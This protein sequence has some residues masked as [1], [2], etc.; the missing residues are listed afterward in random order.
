MKR[1]MVLAALATAAASLQ[2]AAPVLKEPV[3]ALPVMRTS[4][5]V[6]GT[7]DAD[8][9]KDAAELQQ[10][11]PLRQDVVFPGEANVWFG[12][13]DERLYIAARMIVSPHG[14]VKGP[15]P[16]NRRGN[17]GTLGAFGGDCFELDFTSDKDA[18]KESVL[19]MIVS[20]TGCYYSTGTGKGLPV[21]WDPP[22]FKTASTEKDGY[23]LFEY[24]I[25]L[26]EIGFADADWAKHGVRI[27][28]N[29]KWV[30]GN[31]F[32][33]QS[34]LT[35]YE[36]AFGMAAGCVRT[37][38]LDDAPVVQLQT[39]GLAGHGGDRNLQAY[40][41]KLR[42]AN[43]TAKP[44]DL[45]VVL[46]GK[47]VN[48][49]PLHIEMPLTL[50]PGEEKVFDEK[51]AVLSD[52]AVELDVNVTS[53]DGATKY[54]SR[55]MK[56]VPNFYRIEW[57][58]PGVKNATLKCNMAYYPSYNKMRVKSNLSNAKD[59]KNADVTF[60]VSAVPSGKVLK[61]FAAKSNAE[62]VVEGIFDLPDLAAE[63]KASGS[64]DYRLV[65]TAKD[66]AVT[67]R[68]VRHVFEWEG[69]RI[70]L[71]D[72]IPAP[73]EP[74]KREEG[75]GKRE[76]IVRVVLRE[77]TVDK[78]TG[79]WKQVTAAGKDVLA[80]PMRF[81]SVGSTPTPSTYTYS[82]EW[83]VDGLM[84]WRLTL[85]PGHYEPMALE[86]PIKAERAPLMHVCPD[87][88]RI[89]YAGVVPAGEGV[90]WDS[91]K[92][93]HEGIIGDYVP[94]I[95]VGGPLRGIAVF[96]ENNRGWIEAEGVRHQEIVREKDG[97]VVLRLNLIGKACDITEE[98][99][100]RIGFMATPTKPM[101]ENWRA[102]D[103]GHFIG[104]GMCW[105]AGQTD[106]DVCPWD[107][108]TEFW[109]KLAETRR[110]G[111]VDEAFL[112]ATD[113]RYPY[114]GEKGSKEWNGHREQIT[115][116][117]RSGFSS[118]AGNRGKRPMTWYTNARGVDFSTKQGATFCDEWSRQEW[119]W[120]RD[121]DILAHRDYD[122]DPVPSFRDYAAW[123]YK[124]AIEM[125]VCEYYYWDDIYLS[126]NFDL[127]G[128][129]AY[130][131]PEGDIQPAS[132]VF[133]MR[134]LV[135]RCA[136]L[137]AEMGKPCRG[138]W[139]HMTSTAIAPV[140]SFAGLNYDL[141][142]GGSI[143]DF[144]DRYGRAY[145]LA[146][147]LGRQHGNYVKVMG[148]FGKTTP[149]ERKR[150]ERCGTGVMLVYEFNWG[151]C[152]AWN[153]INTKLVDWGYRTP[154]VKVWNDFDE[155]IPFPVAFSGASVSSL[156]MAHPEKRSALVIVSDN[157]DGGEVT[158]RPD[159]AALGLPA[160]FTATDFE[161]GAAIPVK[162]G[163][164]KVTLR[165]HDFAIICF[166]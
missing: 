52:E 58:K 24:S 61:T 51:G 129:D 47:P 135:K 25:P 80:R 42:V 41:V 110:T 65:M 38:F 1:L 154:A 72:A 75:R 122:M 145:M 119:M 91:S 21:A 79:L 5:V 124:K 151:L 6:D 116:H 165:K 45:K 39:V 62:G 29:W 22:G 84:D 32:G 132:G 134:A 100:I 127:V 102:H 13:D 104:S 37:P 55:W 8:E 118:Y 31:G 130:V 2:A 89:S 19:H 109:A 57:L 64:A 46:H 63:T 88:I 9:W 159:A 86:I 140:L 115:R 3:V 121:F 36:T 117:Y 111:K 20:S 16:P 97:T 158:V 85:K 94:Y 125:G 105:G 82:T 143:N 157:V 142:D 70:G 44:L 113:A 155:D 71:S 92:Q 160:T 128:T 103:P 48:S 153:A 123:W 67:N 76:E 15:P 18:A 11:F 35:P 98:R 108:T 12:R 107:G 90:V 162:D 101:P 4:P 68:F 120:T 83:D 49:Q 69:N 74:V 147:T 136:V 95:W 23:W 14:L 54:Y 133:N 141:E 30:G 17:G 59:G 144:Q 60:T 146:S 99:T 81:V 43:P 131:L 78:T 126:P 148:Y 40:P 114:A 106:S 27:A 112:K 96:G 150:L 93:P 66:V 161:T 10:F 33:V 137:Q 139:V 152:N 166:K 149:E 77:H 53:A 34:S 163:A 87:A 164:A 73:F 56:F 26:K 50:Q 156:A 28:R 138:N 7:I